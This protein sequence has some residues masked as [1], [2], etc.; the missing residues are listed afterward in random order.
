MWTEENDRISK[1]QGWGLFAVD[2]NDDDLQIMK[3]D[4]ADVF[5]Y[6]DEAVG[7]VNAMASQG[8]WTALMAL[9]LDPHSRRRVST[10]AARRDLNWRLEEVGIFPKDTAEE[11]WKAVADYIQTS[12]YCDEGHVAVGTSCLLCFWS[13]IIFVPEEAEECP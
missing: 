3:L 10:E 7:F 13:P 2:G 12:C 5:R 8:D 4:E 6:D 1:S 11:A 9:R